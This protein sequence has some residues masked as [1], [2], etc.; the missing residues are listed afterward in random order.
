MD[1]SQTPTIDVFTKVDKVAEPG[2]L[3]RATR[4][5]PDACLVSSSTG[6]GIPALVDRVVRSGTVEESLVLAVEDGAGMARLRRETEVLETVYHGTQ[7][8]VRYR[9]ARH[10]AERVR[11]VAGEGG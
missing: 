8:E 7:V 2:I 11:R 6:A 10:W 3:E 1:L 5:Y 9:V 4:L